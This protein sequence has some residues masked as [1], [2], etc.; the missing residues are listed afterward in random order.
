MFQVHLALR[1]RRLLLHSRNLKLIS[2]KASQQVN[3]KNS[4]VSEMHKTLEGHLREVPNPDL[5]R[6]QGAWGQT[7]E[8]RIKSERK[9]EG[10][11][12]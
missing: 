12:L 6:E 8:L 10:M 11:S 7:I 4:V 1:I 3:H 2:R 5:F 9:L